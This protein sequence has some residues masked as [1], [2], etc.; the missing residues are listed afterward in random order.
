MRAVAAK[1]RIEVAKDRF[2]V[3]RG[4]AEAGNQSD[5]QSPRPAGRPPEAAIL[6]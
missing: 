3:H 2:V 5:A 1:L 4:P 6:Y